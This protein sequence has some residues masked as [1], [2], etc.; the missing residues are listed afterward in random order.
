MK[1][2]KQVSPAFLMLIYALQH[3]KLEMLSPDLSCLS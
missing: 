3:R 2:Q 1:L